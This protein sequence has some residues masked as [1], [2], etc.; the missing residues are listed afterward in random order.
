V[1][2]GPTLAVPAREDEPYDAAYALPAKLHE[3]GVPFAISAGALLQ[4]P[5]PA[6]PAGWRR[7]SGCRGRRAPQR[8]ARSRAD[9]RVGDKLGSIEVGK[10]ATLF[11]VGRRSAGD[12]TLDPPRLDRPDAR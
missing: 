5:H 2:L 12:A 1:I 8:D 7:R 3:R 11:D 10:D 4:R 6:V 9:P